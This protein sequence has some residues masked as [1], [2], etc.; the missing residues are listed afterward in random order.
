[1]FDNYFNQEV[2][3]IFLEFFHTATLTEDEKLLRLEE[4]NRIY[5]LNELTKQQTEYA[6]GRLEL[7]RADLIENSKYI[8]SDLIVFHLFH[9][10]YY[11][12]LAVKKEMLKDI[13]R[14]F[15]G[16]ITVEDYLN[17]YEVSFSNSQDKDTMKKYLYRKGK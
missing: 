10:F 1:M 3:S 11:S 4:A 8:Q 12:S 7:S 2:L 16:D 9:K 6:S 17:K 15:N 14:I 13:Q 5:E